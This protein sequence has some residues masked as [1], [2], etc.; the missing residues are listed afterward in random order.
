MA[1]TMVG[2]DV[3]A[4]NL[5]EGLGR[6]R[7]RAMRDGRWAGKMQEG[8]RV[9]VGGWEHH[10]DPNGQGW[11]WLVCHFRCWYEDG[12]CT[13]SAYD[14]TYTT[15]TMLATTHPIP[16]QHRI[17]LHHLWHLL[18]PKSCICHFLKGGT[19][20]CGL[21][22]PLRLSL[23]SAH[24]SSRCPPFQSHITSYKATGAA[25]TSPPPW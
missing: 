20:L 6:M 19:R 7:G 2:D 18:S 14:C 11:G 1:T 3:K 15:T 8:R 5:N 9:G 24:P 22:I 21:F 12:I 16:D 17:L 10:W 13:K 23:P 4:S 25:T